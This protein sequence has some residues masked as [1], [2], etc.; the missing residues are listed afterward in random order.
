M[1]HLDAAVQQHE[2]EIAI[3]DGDIRYHRTAQR[4]TSVVICRRL[5]D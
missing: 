4:I 1:V 2:F 5:K 3:T